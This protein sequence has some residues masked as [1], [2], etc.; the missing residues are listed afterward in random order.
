MDQALENQHG[1]YESWVKCNDSELISM[2]CSTQLNISLY[3]DGKFWK[4]LV[5]KSF[6]TKLQELQ[7]LQ[8]LQVLKGLQ[9]TDVTGVTYITQVNTS[10][11]DNQI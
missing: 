5:T 11:K 4:I 3:Q 2:I 9:V 10:H 1:C 8:K 6:F 7:M